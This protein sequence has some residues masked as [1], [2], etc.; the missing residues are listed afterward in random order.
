MAV[1]VYAF[2]SIAATPY[3]ALGNSEPFNLIDLGAQGLQ[4]GNFVR[5]LQLFEKAARVDPTDS[6]AIV[7]FQHMLDK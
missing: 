7:S 2:L 5:A 4:G 1:T 3:P 6:Q